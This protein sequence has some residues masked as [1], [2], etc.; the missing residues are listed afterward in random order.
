MCDIHII[1]V[2]FCISMVY[3]SEVV[4]D[5]VS[6]DKKYVGHYMELI[7]YVD[8]LIYVKLHKIVSLHLDYHVMSTARPS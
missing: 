2:Y 8:G 5:N 1:C 6:I 3:G 7:Y 4:F